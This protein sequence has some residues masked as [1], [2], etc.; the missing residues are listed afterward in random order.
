VLL[1]D[2]VPMFAPGGV[3]VGLELTETRP[4]ARSCVLLM[5]RVAG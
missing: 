4:I 1:G 2:V 3:R 5:C